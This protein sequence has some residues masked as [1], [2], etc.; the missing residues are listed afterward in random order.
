MRSFGKPC[1]SPQSGHRLPPS[2]GFGTGAKRPS[3]ENLP[4]G[5]P[6]PA[7][8]HFGRVGVFAGD[9][10][11]EAGPAPPAAAGPAVI[12]RKAPSLAAYLKPKRN[13]GKEAEEE[14]ESEEK[15]S[16]K[17]EKE[18]EGAQDGGS[19]DLAGL[20][21]KILALVSRAGGRT[22]AGAAPE[23]AEQAESEEE[24]QSG[25]QEEIEAAAESEE[26]SGE[27]KKKRKR[28]RKRKRKKK[29]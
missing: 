10:E 29:C 4:G 5:A 6:A 17:K 22:E 16:E 12:Q 14:K 20:V 11:A 8:H 3:L 9:V 25:D 2:R 19:E 1:H 23:E 15:E 7:R 13:P 18:A 21:T 26:G 24:A 27:R 28:K